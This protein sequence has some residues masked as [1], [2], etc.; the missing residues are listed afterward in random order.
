MVSNGLAGMS[1][2]E[3][4]KDRF[5]ILRLELKNFRCFGHLT[6][7]FD[8]RLTVLVGPNGCGKSSVL[9]AIARAFRFAQVDDE[10]GDKN[11]PTRSDIRLRLASTGQMEPAGRARIGVEASFFGYRKEWWSERSFVKER[12]TAS[13]GGASSVPE[14]DSPESLGINV[15]PG[16][17]PDAVVYPLIAYYPTK[18]LWGT[19]DAA[20]LF[21]DQNSSQQSGNSRLEAYRECLASVA[22]FRHFVEWFK[23]YSYEAQKE[24][25]SAI[26]S[27]HSP[28]RVLSAVVQAVDIV[29][30][31]SGWGRLAWDFAE[32]EPTAEHHLHGRMQIRRL[33]DGIRTMIGLVADAAH[34]A[35]RLNRFLAEE[36]CAKTPGIILIDEVDLHLHPE[37][38]QVV[39]DGLQ[40][41]FPLV[42]FVVTTHSPQVL[43]SI[44]RESIRILAQQDQDNWSASIPDFSPLAKESGDAL[45]YVMNVH[46]TPDSP[47]LDLVHQY[48][49]LIRAGKDKSQEASQ[50]M[51]QLGAVGYQFTD[52]EKAQHEIWKRRAGN[53]Q[54]VEH[55]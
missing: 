31:P 24:L 53:R 49:K 6:V 22:N 50:L 23:R 41:A 21:E 39:L 8:P 2:A 43:T 3:D 51:E 12:P 5:N 44:R 48:E 18:R 19:N 36:A 55:D 54:V 26:P 7:D 33:S 32:D 34:R 28:Q 29:L 40:R 16:H 42:Q 45:A 17:D 1:M 14:L 37:W 4:P 47:I 11:M 38:Q 35:A 13:Q 25:V 30:Q 20:W 9:D 46:P 27:Q 15:Q 52:A 10:L